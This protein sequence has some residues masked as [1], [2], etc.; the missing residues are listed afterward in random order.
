[1]SSPAVDRVALANCLI[2]DQ[3]D[4]TRPLGP[5]CDSGAVEVGGLLPSAYLPAALRQ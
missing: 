3:R 1:L 5:L 2:T 4:A